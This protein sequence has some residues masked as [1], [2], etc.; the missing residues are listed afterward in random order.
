MLKWTLIEGKMR[1][2]FSM[3]F[4]AGVIMLTSRVERRGA[5]NQVAG[6]FLRRNMWLV[7]FEMLHATFN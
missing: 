5:G 4:G 6:I 7:V 1:G 3:L 2:L